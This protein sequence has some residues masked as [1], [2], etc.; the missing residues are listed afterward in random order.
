MYI[1]DMLDAFVVVKSWYV[2]DNFVCITLIDMLDDEQSCYYPP[3]P[4]KPQY[5]PNWSL[6]IFLKN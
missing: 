2:E 4:F 5:S 6:Y 3:Y 1:I